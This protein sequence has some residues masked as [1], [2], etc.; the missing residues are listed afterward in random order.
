MPISLITCGAGVGPFG[1]RGGDETRQVSLGG[2]ESAPS[3]KISFSQS[4]PAAPATAA[5]IIPIARDDLDLSHVEAPV[6]IHVVAW[7]R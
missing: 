2:R 5:V 7:K 1:A 4:Y 3:L 6:H